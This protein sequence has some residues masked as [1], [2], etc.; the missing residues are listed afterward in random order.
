LFRNLVLHI[1]DQLPSLEEEEDQAG[2]NDQDKC[3]NEIL[4]IDF[5]DLFD[6]MLVITELEL[7][8]S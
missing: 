8:F 7:W 6:G 1:F 5:F 2:R 4:Y 3:Q